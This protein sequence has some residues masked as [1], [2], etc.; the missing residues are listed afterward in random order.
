MKNLFSHLLTP[1][2][3]KRLLTFLVPASFFL[4]ALT[5]I[6]FATIFEYNFDEGLYLIRSY[7]HMS[8]YSL[9]Q[10][11]WMDQPPLLVLL[12]SGL[13]K[14]SGPDVFIARLIILV[15]STLIIWALYA[16]ISKTQNTLSALWTAVAII[17]SSYYVK[18]SL[19]VVSALP[20]I[21][22]SILSV[23]AVFL[24]QRDYRKKYLLLSGVFFAL[25]IMTR[26]FAVIFLPGIIAELF[27]AER[28]RLKRQNLFAEGIN[29]GIIWFISFLLIV[30]CVSLLVF[31]ID[32]SQIIQPYILARKMAIQ[33]GQG[34]L[35]W[36]GSALDGLLLALGA[37][38]F[39]SRREK[40]FF[41][42]PSLTLICGLLVFSMHRPLWIYHQFYIVVPMYWLASFSI[43]T[44]CNKISANWKNKDKPLGIFDTLAIGFILGIAFLS[45]VALP[46]V[47]YGRLVNQVTEDL[48]SDGIDIV[49]LMKKYSQKTHLV[50]TDRP[51][52]AFYA[53]LPTDP[54]LATSSLKRISTGLLTFRD[55]ADI[56]RERRPELILF[57]RHKW[58]VFEEIASILRQDYDLEYENQAGARLYVLKS[59]KNQSAPQQTAVKAP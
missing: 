14:I 58:W 33:P 39:S 51:V 41:L 10:T 4:I 6:P 29:A 48:T 49:S 24:Y 57:A 26:F 35:E 54:Y 12:L 3:P 46:M 53:G 25:A 43:Y 44:L 2:F 59:L 47:K 16:I 52:F 50:V 45:L 56:I 42:A 1:G 7:L 17:F 37:F 40:R 27:I 38:I 23:Y 55:Y 5:N 30:L 22:L 15:F 28:Q 34:I 31:P 21:A 8:G 18:F 13:F 20:T 32:F 19:T 11:V 9:Y 36:F